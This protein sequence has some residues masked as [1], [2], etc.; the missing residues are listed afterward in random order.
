MDKKATSE[1]IQSLKEACRYIDPKDL[2][3]ITLQ[4]LYL[5]RTMNKK[6]FQNYLSILTENVIDT[7]ILDEIHNLC[8][9]D[10]PRY[11]GAKNLQGDI[12]Y[13]GSNIPYGFNED[14][15]VD[16]STYKL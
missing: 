3:T 9:T 6:Q 2:Y 14:G 5:S 7:D 11:A 13:Q 1:K 4:L 15:E 10:N 8:T 12:V 16:I